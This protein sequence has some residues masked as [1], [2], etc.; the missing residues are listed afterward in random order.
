MGVGFFLKLRIRRI[1]MQI[2]RASLWIYLGRG[3][4]ERRHALQT[5]SSRKLN[6]NRS[7][8]ART[9]VAFCTTRR[10]KES[11]H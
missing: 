4:A 7:L 2:S 3:P 10:M 1:I 11:L 9:S 6:F 5:C 8:G